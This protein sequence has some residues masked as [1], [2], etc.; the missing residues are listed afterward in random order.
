MLANIVFLLYKKIY[1]W[2]HIIKLKS[3]FLL[4][5]LG[6]HYK[7]SCPKMAMQ[8]LMVCTEN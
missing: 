1:I 8:K 7:D 2:F 3:V 5:K 4:K 6:K